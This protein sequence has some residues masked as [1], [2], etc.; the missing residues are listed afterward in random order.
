[1]S[2]GYTEGIKYIYISRS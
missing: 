2:A 1:M